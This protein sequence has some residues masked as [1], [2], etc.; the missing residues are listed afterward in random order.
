MKKSLTGK[1]AGMFMVGLCIAGLYHGGKEKRRT[2]GVIS[3]GD[4]TS[5]G[6]DTPFCT[7][8]LWVE[9]LLMGVSTEEDALTSLGRPDEIMKSDDGATRTLGFPFGAMVFRADDQSMHVLHKIVWTHNG[10][11]APRDINVGMD[12]TDALGR[13]PFETISYVSLSERGDG[14]ATLTLDAAGRA[15]RFHIHFR[16]HKVSYLDLSIDA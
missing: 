7:M 1:A 9:G 15:A 2:S 3:A 16:E 4:I 11:R 6:Q 10:L 13:F 8:D 5:L 12:A 14:D